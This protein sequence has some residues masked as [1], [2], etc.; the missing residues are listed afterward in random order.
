[1]IFT[2]YHNPNWSKSRK[3]LELLEKKKLEINIV[4]Y[5]KNPPTV[6]DLKSISKKLNLPPGKFLRT[7][8][9]RYKEL[10]LGSFKGS[11]L[12]LLQIINQ[13]YSN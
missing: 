4:N 13:H 1:M 6:N 12:E 8:D 3:S 2:I 10:D 9:S 7:N 11:E 5:I